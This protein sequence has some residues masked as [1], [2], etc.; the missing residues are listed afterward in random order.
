[1]KNMKEQKRS[2]EKPHVK[3]DDMVVVLSGTD[4]GKKGR[5][6]TVNREKGVAYVEGVAYMKKHSRPSK[7]MGKG[8]IVEKEGPVAL[9]KLGLFC[10]NC[11]KVSR[12]VMVAHKDEKS[13][14]CTGCKEPL[15]R[16]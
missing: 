12:A 16:Q 13:R 11:N 4:K 7:K 8:G 10:S 5:V 2:V 3:K 6:L 14:V 9:S 1:M 15:G